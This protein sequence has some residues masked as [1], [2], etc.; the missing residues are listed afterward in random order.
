MH[1]VQHISTLYIAESNTCREK[2]NYHGRNRRRE[3]TKP[4]WMLQLPTRPSA[5]ET[6][7]RLLAWFCGWLWALEQLMLGPAIL[8]S[9]DL[10]GWQLLVIVL[11]RFCLWIRHLRV[12]AWAPR[13]ASWRAAAGQSADADPCLAVC[14]KTSDV[15]AWSL[16]TCKLD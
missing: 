2:R 7:A 1:R 9:A 14:F 11:A 3:Q 4:P 8:E 6:S 15:Q 5:K 16:R 10:D 13:L 12:R